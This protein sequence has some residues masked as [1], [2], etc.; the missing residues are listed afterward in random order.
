M[1]NITLKLDGALLDRIRHVAVDER[2]SVS[3]WVSTVVTRELNLRDSFENNRKFI[4]NCLNKGLS[5]GGSTL[6]R[7]ES[8]ER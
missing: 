5:L 7:E 8:H 6:S 3:A 1:K 4:L 2:T